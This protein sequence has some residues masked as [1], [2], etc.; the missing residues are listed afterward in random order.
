[1]HEFYV[2]SWREIR[3]LLIMVTRSKKRETMKGKRARAGGIALVENGGSRR[4]FNPLL[5][6]EERCARPLIDLA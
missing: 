2:N 5:M 6:L 3:Y 1:M 4:R